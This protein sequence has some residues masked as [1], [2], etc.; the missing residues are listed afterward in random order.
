MKCFIKSCYLSWRWTNPEPCFPQ[1]L[2]LYHFLGRAFALV[3]PDLRPGLIM[4]YI[5]LPCI[6]LSVVTTI[7]LLMEDK[8]TNTQTGTTLSET[9]K[10]KKS[11]N[12]NQKK[13]EERFIQLFIPHHTA[14]C[15]SKGGGGVGT[16]EVDWNVAPKLVESNWWLEESLSGQISM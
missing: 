16:S 8:P 7:L 15:Q 1:L 9:I 14:L 4:R 2:W 5:N 12:G 11:Q 10:K 3:S 6:T 13:T